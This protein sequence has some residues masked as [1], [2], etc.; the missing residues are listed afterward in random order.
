MSFRRAE[1]E[2]E[3]AAFLDGRAVERRAPPDLRARALARAR[4]TL[5]A[6]G[7][8]WPARP[9]ELPVALPPAGVGR[10]ALL[11]A[12][13]VAS[14]V[15][16]SGA[17]GAFAA[18]HGRAVQTPPVVVPLSPAPA[19]R[20]AGVTAHERAADL[21][22]VA[23]QRPV[24]ARFRRPARVPSGPDPFTAE[25]ALLQR[26]EAAYAHRDFSST[27]TFVAEHARRF[28]RGHLAEEREALRVQSLVGAQRGDE[29]HRAAE[30]F[31]ARFPRSVLLPRVSRALRPALGSVESTATSLHPNPLEP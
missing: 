1:L 6:D 23:T 25:I 27:L 29:A 20:V 13:L 14:V 5:A 4:A 3:L 24:S 22:A 26:A 17:V 21:P 19:V 15:V 30:A 12:A 28:P 8:I 10:R 9:R 18:L 16:A 2:P 31:S 11:R 7:V